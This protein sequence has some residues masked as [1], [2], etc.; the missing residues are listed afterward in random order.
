ML[1]VGRAVAGMGC[2]GLMN[3]GLVIIATAVPLERRPSLTGVMMGC[4]Q[5]GIVIGPLIGGAFTSYSTWRWCF[6]VNLPIGAVVAFG[7]LLVPIPD[8]FAMPRPLDVLR[9]LHHE[10]DLVGFALIAPAAVQLMLALQWGGS[11]YPWNSPTV[12]GLFC[13]AA[14]TAL[15]WGVWNWYRGDE[16]LIPLSLIRQRALWAAALTQWFLLTTVYAASFFLPI[17]FQAVF[18]ATPIMS[19]VYVL[20]SILSQLV[21]AVVSGVLGRQCCHALLARGFASNKV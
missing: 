13:G 8:Q 2:S 4:S 12:I 10:L 5:L 21:A 16:A 3:G 19:G 14:G 6:Y 17:Y 20:A 15:V 9:R 11:Q 7:M 18:G 1:I